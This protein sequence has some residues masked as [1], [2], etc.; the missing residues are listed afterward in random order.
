MNDS[1][2]IDGFNQRNVKLNLTNP[3]KV[4]RTDKNRDI[5]MGKG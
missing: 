3:K 4:F 2:M 5:F 1:Q